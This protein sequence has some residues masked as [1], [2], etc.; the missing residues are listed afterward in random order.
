MN[1]PTHTKDFNNV[2]ID[3]I[4]DMEENKVNEKFNKLNLSPEKEIQNFKTIY[5]EADLYTKKQILISARMEID[6]SRK[7]VIRTPVQ[8]AFDVKK[9]LADMMIKGLLPEEFTMAFRDGKEITD[10]EAL[11]IYEDLRELGV[12]MNDK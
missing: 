6:L 2:L 12:K 4:L 7:Q 3:E 8:T 1:K 5:S 11:S 10:E 9:R